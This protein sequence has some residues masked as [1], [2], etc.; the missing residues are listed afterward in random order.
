MDLEGR[1]MNIFLAIGWSVCLVMGPLAPDVRLVAHP[2]RPGTKL[3]VSVSSELSIHVDLKKGGRKARAF[4]MPGSIEFTCV[5]TVNGA[6]ESG[7]TAG[8]L[9][10]AKAHEVEP[11][12]DRA[13][14]A[15]EPD[16]SMRSYE[17]ER[18]GDG[19]AIRGSRGDL[20]YREREVTSGVAQAVFTAPPL[21]AF[22]R[23][24]I[25]ED[26]ET[27]ELPAELGQTLLQLLV[28]DAKVQSMK[29][30]LSSD[31]ARGDGD[32]ATFEARA[33]LQAQSTDDMAM[34]VTVDLTGELAVGRSSG[35][36][37]SIKMTGPV[38]LTG[39]KREGG[40][41]QELEGKGT[42]TMSYTV[43]IP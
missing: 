43:E 40:S 12:M 1:A 35:L 32:T 18:S 42:W 7:V 20:S 24:R 22:L 37:L 8:T 14:T 34:N 16:Y 4:D 33:R 25:V 39:K 27:V 3:R 29:I 31:R 21:V 6:D 19:F 38:N 15:G 17:A 30:K 41:R 26:G 13:P 10:F 11:E 36:V 9:A 2:P 5:A 28:S 23:G